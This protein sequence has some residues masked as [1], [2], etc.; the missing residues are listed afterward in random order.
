MGNVT[1]QERRLAT[2]CSTDVI[3]EGADRALLSKNHIANTF[4]LAL[5]DI[6][7][8]QFSR[9]KS[10]RKN[11]GEHRVHMSSKEVNYPAVA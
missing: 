4:A 11:H 3:L 7:R 1:G 6:Q 8:R 5:P 2:W 9:K 10:Q